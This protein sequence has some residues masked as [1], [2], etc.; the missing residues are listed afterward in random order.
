MLEE[1]SDNFP[2][3]FHEPLKQEP[4]PDRVDLRPWCSA[5][6]NQLDLGSCTA[7][8]IANSYELLLNKYRPREFADLSRLFIYYNTRLIEGNLTEDAGGYVSTGIQALEKYG[9]CT[10]AIWPYNP[11][12][13]TTP[14]PASCYKDAEKRKITTYRQ[15]SGVNDIL[16][17]LA[18]GMPVTFG[19][20]VY[21]GFMDV[22]RFDPIVHVPVKDEPII[23]GHAMCMVGY[24]LT[25]Q[26]FLAKNSFGT[27]WG[28][29]GY[30]WLPF[31]YIRQDV[32]DIWTFSL[33]DLNQV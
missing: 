18:S 5:V 23:G 30:C 25:K 27:S 8:A 12:E 29:K 4:L 16:T 26:L 1:S 14:P 6:D 17:T 32:F 15:L 3:N 10:E 2:K 11:D 21:N 28:D 9:A 33:P 13:F 31:N 24:D 20:S 7:N 22:D 19:M